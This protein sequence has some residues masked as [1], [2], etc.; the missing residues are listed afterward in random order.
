[1]PLT[2][3]GSV[4]LRKPRTV[5]EGPVFTKTVS[6]ITAETSPKSFPAGAKLS[7]VRVRLPRRPLSE[8]RQKRIQIGHFCRLFLTTKTR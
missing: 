6:Q 1:M 3:Q 2:N 8:T 4:L 7:S 5:A